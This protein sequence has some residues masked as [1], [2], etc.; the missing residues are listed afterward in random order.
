MLMLNSNI[1]TATSWS[2]LLK[3]TLALNHYLPDME[4]GCKMTFEST[5]YSG[6][7]RLLIYT[8]SRAISPFLSLL[9]I[10]LGAEATCAQT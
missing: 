7:L 2:A 5:Q 8:Y 4:D 3:R 1:A 9:H 6:I 10:G